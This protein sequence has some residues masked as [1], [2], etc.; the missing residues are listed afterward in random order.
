MRSFA[1][2]NNSGVHPEVINAIIKANEDH[3]IAYGDDPWS[4][5]A[6]ELIK[7]EFGPTAY[8]LFV[9]NGTGANAIALRATTRSYHSIL[10]AASAHIAV[11][12]CGA[13]TQMT[14]CVLKELTTP[15]GKLTPALIATQLHGFGFEHHSQPRVVY[16]S[17][18]SEFGT[19]YTQE[20]I[21]AIAELVHANGMY[22]H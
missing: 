19:V 5:Q 6:T 17:Q 14:G 3:A 15:N 21:K 8:P 7:Q 4:E 10:C 20:E 16:I 13:P 1:S 22:L 18:C 12:E 11:D 2:D 9:F